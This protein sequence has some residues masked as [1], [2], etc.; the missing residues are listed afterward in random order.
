MITKEQIEAK[1][2]QLEKERDQLISTYNGAIQA[3]KQWLDSLT[4][5]ETPETPKET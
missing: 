3:N 5:P 2:T 1:V 4:P